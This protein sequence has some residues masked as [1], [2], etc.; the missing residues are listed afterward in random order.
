MQQESNDILIGKKKAHIM[1]IVNSLRS[2]SKI[3]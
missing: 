1:Y 2:E 3:K